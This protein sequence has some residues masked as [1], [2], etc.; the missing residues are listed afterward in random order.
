VLSAILELKTDVSRCEEVIRV[1]WEVEKRLNTIVVLG[2]GTRCD[3]NGEETVVAPVLEKLG[4]T[5]H[6]AKT[7]LGLGRAVLK[8]AEAPAERQLEKVSP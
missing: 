1:V 8:R 7:N 4:Y 3:E 5:L 6:R 2:V